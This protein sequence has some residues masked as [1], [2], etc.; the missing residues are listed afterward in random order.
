MGPAL[1]TRVPPFTAATESLIFKALIAC[2]QRL[3]RAARLPAPPARGIV[4]C[5][6]AASLPHPQSTLWAPPRKSLARRFLAA[7]STSASTLTWPVVVEPASPRRGGGGMHG[8]HARRPPQATFGRWRGAPHR[9]MAPPATRRLRSGHFAAFGHEDCQRASLWKLPQDD[10][11]D[12][13]QRYAQNH[14]GNS[15]HRA[16]CRQADHH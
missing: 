7:K 3:N 1:R 4:P 9:K 10:H 8:F 6:G 5:G 16:P 15:P 14:A 12:H 2:L 11:C 13:H